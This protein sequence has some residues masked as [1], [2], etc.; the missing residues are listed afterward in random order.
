VPP[1]FGFRGPNP[2]LKRGENKSQTPPRE[3]KKT[4]RPGKKKKNSYL[5]EKTSFLFNSFGKNPFLFFPRKEK[6]TKKKADGME[7][8]KD[9][10]IP[11]KNG[12]KQTPLKGRL[13]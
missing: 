11:K 1:L 9:T 6:K 5:E 2:T 10:P 4:G 12:H 13:L 3:R 7:I 8:K